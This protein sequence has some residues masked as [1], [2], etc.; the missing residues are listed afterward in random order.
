MSTEGNKATAIHPKAPAVP[1]ETRGREATQPAD[2]GVGLF[3][4]LIIMA[5]FYLAFGFLVWFAWTL[6]SQWR[7]H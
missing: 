3:R 1:E 4:G 7:G 2:E 5:L 6:F